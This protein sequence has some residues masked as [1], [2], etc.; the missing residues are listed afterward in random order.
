MLLASLFLRVVHTKS[1]PSGECLPSAKDHSHFHCFA[2][3]ANHIHQQEQQQVKADNK[4]A[5]ITAAVA[6]AR[7]KRDAQKITNNQSTSDKTAPAQKLNNTETDNPVDLVN[8]EE[9]QVEIKKR[10]IAVAVAK[11]NAKKAAEKAAEK[12]DPL[13]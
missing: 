2:I 7:A 13:L 1:A 10:K 11:A 6:K 4:Q 8:I 9:Q 3:H 12:N 5:R